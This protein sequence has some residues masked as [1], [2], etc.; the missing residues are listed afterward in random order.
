MEYANEFHFQDDFVGM[1]SP[2]NLWAESGLPN[3]G[4]PKCHEKRDVGPFLFF[5]EYFAAQRINF[6]EQRDSVTKDNQ[7]KYATWAT[8]VPQLQLLHPNN[9]K[10]P[11][12]P[13][14][15]SE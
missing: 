3:F 1:D 4:G 2:G 8:F 9:F 13:P 7:R 11:V 6:R 12:Q 10:R 15:Y 5:A 14:F